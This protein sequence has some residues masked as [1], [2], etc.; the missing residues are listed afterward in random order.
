MPK[1]GSNYIFKFCN[2]II[3]DL[4][5]LKTF[6]SYLYNDIIQWQKTIPQ[7]NLCR[8]YSANFAELGHFMKM[9][10]QEIIYLNC[11]KTYE[12]MINHGSYA[13]NFSSCEIKA[14]KKCRPEWDSNPWSLGYQYSALPTSY[15][16]NWELVTLWVHVFFVE[17]S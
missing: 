10:I 7:I 16:V 13:H 1:K 9:N 6:S 15:Q 4:F 5:S 3:L 12:D 17:D 11:G 14:W 2:Y 8:S